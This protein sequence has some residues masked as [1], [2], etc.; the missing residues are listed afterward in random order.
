MR[1]GVL[2]LN[3]RHRGSLSND[4]GAIAGFL[5]DIGVGHYA[6]PP[7]DSDPEHWLKWQRDLAAVREL[8][9][10]EA[11]AQAQAR[12]GDL[13]HTQV[14][15]WLRDLGRAL[16]FKVWIAAN[17]RSRLVESGVLSEGCLTEL[18]S[19]L[20][21]SPAFDTIRL[22]DV[23]WIAADG[24]RVVAAF[25][26]EHTT[27]IYSGIVRMLDLALGLPEHAAERYFLVAPDEREADV[28]EQFARP[29]FSRVSDLDLRW[30]PYGELRTHRESIARFGSGLKAI[31]AIARPLRT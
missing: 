19:G 5:F 17:D 25:E 21:Q 29:A 2:E 10:K 24:N 1:R 7:R 27:S 28:R 13:T 23:L 3:A 9:A 6:A 15:A 14:Q 4:L 22:I 20:A 18:P 16:G 11:R 26:V 31:E 12:E 30:L 8:S